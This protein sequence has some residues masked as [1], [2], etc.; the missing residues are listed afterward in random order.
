MEQES[1][2]NWLCSHRIELSETVDTVLEK[3]TRTTEKFLPVTDRQE[4]FLGLLSESMLRKACLAETVTAD[5]VIS[6]LSLEL[7]PQFV[8]DFEEKEYDFSVS[9]FDYIPVLNRENKIVDLFRK[10]Q[11]V[12]VQDLPI[13]QLTRDDLSL[14]RDFFKQMGGESRAF[15][16][17]ND[18]N[19]KF[20][21]N[22]LSQDQETHTVVFGAIAPDGS[23]AGLCFLIDLNTGVPWVGIAIAEN[24][25]GHHLGRQLL[26]HLD[27]FAMAGQYGAL[28]LI[29]AVSNQR[30]QGL[31]ERM[32]YRKLGTHSSGEF[33]YIKRYLRNSNEKV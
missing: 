17:R 10:P 11:H 3:F 20:L 29:T 5:T 21:I 25:K 24:W 30:G 32:G 23:L 9:S 22:T 12:P 27:Q 15:F 4:K 1:V 31:Y 14:I 13:R 2:R 16:N 18:G 19:Q 28:M 26:A 8:Y 33:L 6:E 7:C